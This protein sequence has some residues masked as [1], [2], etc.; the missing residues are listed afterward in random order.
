[1]YRIAKKI[2]NSKEYSTEKLLGW[3]WLYHANIDKV[4]P[5]FKFKNQGLFA[6]LPKFIEMFTYEVDRRRNN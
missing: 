5:I 4:N 2:Q 3:I 6:Y 1:M